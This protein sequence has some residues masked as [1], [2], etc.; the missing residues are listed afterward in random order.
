MASMSIEWHE[1]CIE[2][3]KLYL[4]RKLKELN[5]LQREVEDLSSKL[6]GYIKQVNTAKKEG[7]SKFDKGLYKVQ[8]SLSS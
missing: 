7:R 1:Q 2:H 6:D 5:K 3:N 8:R 4:E